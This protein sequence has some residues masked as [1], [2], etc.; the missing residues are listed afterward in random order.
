[1][2][3][4]SQVRQQKRTAGHKEGLPLP[5]IT[6]T[7]TAVKGRSSWRLDPSPRNG[8]LGFSG[9]LWAERTGLSVSAP[10][11]H[12]FRSSGLGYCSASML[13]DP[14]F[15]RLQNEDTG[16]PVTHTY[17]LGRDPKSFCYKN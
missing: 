14:A 10:V 8:G 6:R 17:H 4:R 7:V 12:G 11:D 2:R 5:A 16:P 9:C 13:R 15:L 1:M 3:G